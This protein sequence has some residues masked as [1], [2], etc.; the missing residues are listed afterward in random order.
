ME[1]HVIHINV[2]DF[3]VAVERAMD[4]RL[5]ERPVVIAPE[6][7]ARA[8]VYDMS[9]EAYQAGVRKGMALRRAVRLCPDVRILPPHP[10]RYEQAMQALVRQARPYSPLIEPGEAIDGVV[11]RAPKAYP[12]YDRDYRAAVAAMESSPPTAPTPTAARGESRSAPAVTATPEGT[13]SQE[14][15]AGAVANGKPMNTCNATFEDG[16]RVAAIIDAMRKS[17]DSGKRIDLSF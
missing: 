14:T 8:V 11:A 5:R 15:D 10:S 13:M 3:A 4:R 7:V 16:Y 6:G 12:V 17:S 1:R 9:E 2:A